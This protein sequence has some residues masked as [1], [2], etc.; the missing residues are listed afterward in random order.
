M[1]FILVINTK[2]SGYN[3]PALFC[4]KLNA[5]FVLRLIFVC[6]QRETGME[7]P[8]DFILKLKMKHSNHTFRSEIR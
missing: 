2:N 1:L 8:G 7:T 6:E 3:L 5:H 4:S